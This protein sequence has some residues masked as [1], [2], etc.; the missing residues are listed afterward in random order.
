ME[1]L[2]TNNFI[3]HFNLPPSVLNNWFVKTNSPYFEI[4]DTNTGDIL[5]HTHRG[6]GMAKFSNRD[7]LNIT[8]INYEKFITSIQDEPFKQGRKRCDIILSCTT[9]RYF[10]L[11]E[12]KNRKLENENS[13]KKVRKGAKKQLFS[14][15][16]TLMSV[17]HISAYINSKIEKRCCYFNRQPSPLINLTVINAFNRLS[18]IY[19]DGLK[20]SKPDIEA[21][22]FEFYEYT[23]TQTLTLVN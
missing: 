5:L 1:N 2:L 14:S 3:A 23:G 15:L 20:M 8:V 17:P 4:E 13:E 12:L 10:I 22:G 9:N 6:T 11:G 21:L 7:N 19:P 16:Q 18:N